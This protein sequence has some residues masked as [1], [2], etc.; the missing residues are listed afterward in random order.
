[1]TELFRQSARDLAR[2][3]R[4][5]EV[6]PV[7]VV[8]AHLARIEQVNPV[9]N[10]ITDL[11]P[12][13]ALDQ[14]RRAEKQMMAGEA[15]GPLHGVPMT[16]KSSIEVEGYRCECGT[17]LREGIVAERDATLVISL[18]QAGAIILGTTNTPEF[19]MAYESDNHIYGRTNNPWNLDY[20]AGGSSGGEA[21]AIASGCSAGGFGSD[22]GGSVRVPAHFSGICGLKPTPGVIPRTGHWPACLG[23]SAFIG[24]IGPMAR[25]VEDVRLLLEVTAGVEHHDPSAAPVEMRA[26]SEAEL[27]SVKVGWFADD[28]RHPVTP[29]TRDAVERAAKALADQG[30][31]VEQVEITGLEQAP[32][33]WWTFFGVVATTA[34]KPIV[35][36]REDELHPFSKSLMATQEEAD[37]MTYERFL[38][39]WV[40]R[41]RVR[42]KLLA[43]MEEYRVLLCPTASI[44]AFR[45]GERSWT[46]A[47]EKVCYP[48]PFVYSQIFNLLGNPG[49][50]VP[51][52][53]SAEG[54]PIGVQTVGRPFE[55]ELALSVAAKI[56]E[57]L[58]GFPSPP[59]EAFASDQHREMRVRGAAARARS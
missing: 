30:F 59:E 22:G 52:G 19:L 17:K 16:I 44:A 20:T 46:I 32:D 5:K 26:P 45:H 53:R 21:A 42:S 51:A 36:G 43:Q 54:L 29:E 41:D 24:L 50:V 23:P 35:E 57:A 38:D 39:A 9:L 1:M 10:A 2:R 8:E 48:E 33:L 34:L 6:S 37:A 47:G 55:D 25:T 11:Q 12:E 49:A 40:N 14:A 18:K 13:R 31:T 4:N 28:G 15:T 58:G 27:R 7:E 56:E 3:I